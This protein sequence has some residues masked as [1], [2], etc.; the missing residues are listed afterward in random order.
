MGNVMSR[1]LKAMLPSSRWKEGLYSVPLSIVTLVPIL[2][3]LILLAAIQWMGR[4][5]RG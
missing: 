2:T 4:R 5:P 1:P 3:A